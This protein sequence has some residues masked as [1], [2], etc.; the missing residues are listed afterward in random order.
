MLNTMKKLFGLAPLFI[1]LIVL[2]GC[3]DSNPTN[4]FEPSV[5]NTT[6]EFTFRASNVYVVTTRLT[7][8][9]TNTGATASIEHVSGRSGGTGTL[10][11]LDADG[12]QVYQSEFKSSGTDVTIA[13]NPGEW[14]VIVDLDE[15][16]GSIYFRML[17]V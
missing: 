6:D 16:S 7:Y 12:T 4:S 2:T 17:K 5:L 13:G 10:I 14:S 1:A 11:V 15:Y 3:G 9:W 8:S